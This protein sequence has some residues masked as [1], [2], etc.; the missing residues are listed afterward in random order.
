ALAA[1]EILVLLIEKKMKIYQTLF[2]ASFLFVAGC[3]SPSFQ[4]SNDS[5]LPQNKY[6]GINFDS[7]YGSL[8]KNIEVNERSSILKFIHSYKELDKPYRIYLDAGL[9]VNDIEEA[10]K[11]RMIALKSEA[12]SFKYVFSY[13]NLGSYSK[14]NNG[15]LLYKEEENENIHASGLWIVEHNKS[16]NSTCT[17]KGYCGLEHSDGY[18]EAQ[19]AIDLKDW[20]IPM[21]VDEAKSL[22]DSTMSKQKKLPALIVFKPNSCVSGKGKKNVR[23]NYSNDQLITCD[24]EV[25]EVYLYSSST[26]NSSD[27]PVRTLVRKRS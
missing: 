4:D 11:A 5:L 3:Q 1:P 18:Y 13:V 12:E 8:L 19:I 2:M 16:Y 25:S 10:A 27:I 17:A 21:S 6:K 20:F 23:S 22:L 15:F 9:P 14:E 7:I 26:L 24:S